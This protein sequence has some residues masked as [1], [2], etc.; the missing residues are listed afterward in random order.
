MN[1][2]CDSRFEK[3]REAFQKNFDAG[4]EIGAS[5]A[6]AI[7]GELVV[8][9]WGGHQ[10]VERSIP[11]EENTLTNVW[12]ST[13]TMMF[14]TMVYLADQGEISLYDKV[15]KC[16]PEFAQNGKGNIEIRHLMAHTSGLSGFDE[17]MTHL[18][19]EDHDKCATLLAKQAP[20]WEPGTASGYHAVNQGFLLGEVVRRITGESLG[21]FFRK[22][23]AEPLDAD[24]HIGTGPELDDRCCFV[25]IPSDIPPRQLEPGSV[26][27]RTVT[28]PPM[29]PSMAL[30]LGW[31]RAEI[32]AA[33]GHGN[34][35]SMAK[36]QALMSNRGVSGGVQLLSSSAPDMVFDEQAHGT[37]LVLGVPVRMGMGYGLNGN[38][39]MSP[40]PRTCFWGGWGG[41]LV[42]NDLD[43]RMTFC[44]AMNHMYIGEAGTL[45]DDRGLSLAMAAY[46][47]L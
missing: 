8:D 14:L 19:Y 17:Q 37:D 42:M 16:W 29:V 21:T 11:W 3:V 33:N 40:N 28:N 5:V 35:R 6:I 18:D 41:S 23:I 13:K 44:Y 26:V 4:Y 10:D 2:Y 45:G 27:F 32:A 25:I 24:F 31:R 12:S 7:E 15:A 9:L 30:S 34:A 20:W 39:P 36:V 46:Q 22:N 38:P 1:G 47:S 43:A